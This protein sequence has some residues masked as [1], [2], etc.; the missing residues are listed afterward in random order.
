MILRLPL[1]DRDKEMKI[2]RLL[3][4]SM[5]DRDRQAMILRLS[6]GDR[7]RETKY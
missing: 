2:F 1:G 3:K 4:F 7:D 6:Q 5:K